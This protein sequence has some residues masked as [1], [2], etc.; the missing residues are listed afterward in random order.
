M[1]VLLL[2]LPLMVA[3]VLCCCH[4]TV[5]SPSTPCIMW[6]WACLLAHIAWLAR[7]V[8]VAMSLLLWL[9]VARP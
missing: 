2:R 4:I 6:M 7:D 1:I 8:S 3:T 5:S 9:A